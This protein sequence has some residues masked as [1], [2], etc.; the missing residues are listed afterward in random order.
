MPSTPL[1]ALKPERLS[2]GEQIFFPL[3]NFPEAWNGGEFSRAKDTYVGCRTSG[4]EPRKPCLGIAV[5]RGACE[6]GVVTNELCALP[7]RSV[8]N[9]N[10][11]R[12]WHKADRKG[13]LEM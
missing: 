2:H 8:V 13:R 10:A 12:A 4:G 6:L 3:Y 1:K 7:R 11:R 5:R 9:L